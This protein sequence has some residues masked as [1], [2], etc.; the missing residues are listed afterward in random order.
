M[1]YLLDAA[2]GGCLESKSVNFTACV[3]RSEQNGVS[4]SGCHG[5]V[6]GLVIKK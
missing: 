1:R 6:F 3:N 4:K 5:Y 2:L